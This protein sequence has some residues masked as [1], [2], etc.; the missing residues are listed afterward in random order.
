IYLTDANSKQGPR[1][2]L[3]ATKRV[4]LGPVTGD[5]CRF[6]ISVD[7]FWM[8]RYDESTCEMEPPTPGTPITLEITNG[9]TINFTW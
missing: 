9:P 4:Y 5:R 7:P 8:R 1:R 3:V 2:Q 6:A